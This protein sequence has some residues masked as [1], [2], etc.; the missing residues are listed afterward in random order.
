MERAGA[1]RSLVIELM[2]RPD[3][4]DAESAAL[5]FD[6]LASGNYALRSAVVSSQQLVSKPERLGCDPPCFCVCGTQTLVD[7]EGTECQL[8]VRTSTHPIL[9]TLDAP[10]IPDLCCSR[11]SCL[12]PGLP[13]SRPTCLSRSPDRSPSPS[14]S[15]ASRSPQRRRRRRTRHSHCPSST[16][17]RSETRGYLGRW[18]TGER[19]GFHFWHKRKKRRIF[20][21][22]C[23]VAYSMS[24]SRERFTAKPDVG[25]RQITPLPK[26]NFACQTRTP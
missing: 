20:N 14:R 25:V 18:F 6:E 11:C 3:V 23:R 16:V 4:A 19:F 24:Q 26:S 7:G 17:S 22:V 10:R 8:Q 15:P 21:G 9:S 1:E 5:H 12:S 2:E 13:S